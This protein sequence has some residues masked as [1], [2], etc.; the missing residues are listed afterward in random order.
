[1]TPK[2][3]NCP[4]SCPLPSRVASGEK[5]EQ[6]H[7]RGPCPGKGPP[8]FLQDNHTLALLRCL[9]WPLYF[10]SSGDR[11]VTLTFTMGV[12]DLPHQPPVFSVQNI[13][14]LWLQLLPTFCLSHRTQDTQMFLQ[15]QP[16]LKVATP[17]KLK[18]D[19]NT[20]VLMSYLWFLFVCFLTPH[21]KKGKYKC[22]Y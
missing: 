17:S 21:L 15:P 10:A 14:S 13:T 2:S 20:F 9:F 6:S 8:S 1:M 4:S 19:I 16:L 5:G 12:L 3:C 22:L 11:V 18:Q 7:K